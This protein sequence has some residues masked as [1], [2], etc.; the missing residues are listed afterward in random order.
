MAIRFFT[1]LRDFSFLLHELAQGDAVEELVDQLSQLRPHGPAVAIAL[2]L[3]VAAD[4]GQIPLRQPE[5][6]AHG[7]GFHGPVP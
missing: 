1:A 3:G 7:V 4:R 5:D 2:T 6:I